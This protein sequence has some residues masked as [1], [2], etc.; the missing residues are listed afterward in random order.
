MSHRVSKV[1]RLRTVAQFHREHN[2]FSEPAL[3]WLIFKA[4][5]NGLLEA[6]AIVRIRR[7]VYIEPGNFFHWIQVQ[8]KQPVA[9]INSGNEPRASATG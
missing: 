4:K 2:E 7:R 9:I 5:E 6:G 8:Q 1:R 3:R